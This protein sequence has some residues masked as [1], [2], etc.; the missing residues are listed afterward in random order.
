MRTPQTKIKSSKKGTLAIQVLIYGAVAVIFLSGFVIWADATLKS[1]TR[2]NE[3]ELALSI[4]ES[5]IEYYRW[6]LAHASNDYKDGTGQPGPYTHNY[7]DK[8]GVQIGQFILD[9]TPPPVG[10]TMVTIRS[11]GKVLSDPTIEK[12]VEVKLGIPSFAKYAAVLNANVRFG[13]GTEIF[14]ELF[15]NYGVRVDGL[16]HN[17]VSSALGTYKDPDHSGNSEFGVHTHKDLPPANT[18]NDSFRPNEAPPTSPVP[19]RS[20]VFM[21]GRQFPV[22]A[23]DFTGISANLTQIRTD[24]QASGFYASSSGSQGYHIVLKTNDT[25]DFYRVTSILNPPNG[26]TSVLG[27]Q[28]WGTWTISNQQFVANYPFPANGL[29]FIEDNVWIDGQINTARITVAA[30]KFPETPSNWRAITINNNLLYTNFDGR[31]TIGL[32]AQGNINAGLQSADFLTIDA[33]LISQ[34]GRVGRYYFR[35]PGSNQNRCS[36]YHVRNTITLYGM[37]MSNQRYGFA[38]TDGTGYQNRNII[39][40]PNLLYSPPPSFP[41]TTSG[42]QILSWEE[43]K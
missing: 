18:V 3:K 21:T 37:I 11:T 2:Y 23:I 30:A 9:I 27:E 25:F 5:G 19:N 17:I 42:Y 41:L 29:I 12:I 7:F 39:Y 26:C 10:S 35:P 15:S 43:I 28:D 38:Y 13:Q 1:A 32:I 31:D 14:G 34:N 16:A 20:D 22:P 6:H 36:P 40:D 24:A 4:A 33:A 8:N